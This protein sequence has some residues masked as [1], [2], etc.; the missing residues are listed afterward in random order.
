MDKDGSI[1]SEVETVEIKEE[2]KSVKEVT[3]KGMT[4]ANKN[5][6]SVNRMKTVFP[7]LLL[8][9]GG[10][11]KQWRICVMPLRNKYRG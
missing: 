4:R 1:G 11:S 2:T 8:L 10:G 7:S 5:L 9:I 3:K 6:T